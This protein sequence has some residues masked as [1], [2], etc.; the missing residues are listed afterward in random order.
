[1][2]ADPLVAYTCSSLRD[3]WTSQL[4]SGRVP[5]DFPDDPT[6]L[7]PVARSVNRAKGNRDAAH[8]PPANPRTDFRRRFV[9]L[10][11]QVKARYG[12]SVAE[13][14][15]TAIRAVLAGRASQS[16]RLDRVTSGPLRED[17][18]HDRRLLDVA[19]QV[20]Q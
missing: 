17:F 6:K 5:L 9:T 8:W 12:L 4:V 2:R 20:R 16:P 13:S 1:M 3:G 15:A 14:E 19:S 18:R 10:Q 11:V 7:L